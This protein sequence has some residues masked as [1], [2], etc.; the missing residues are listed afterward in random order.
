MKKEIAAVCI[1]VFILAASLVNVRVFSGITASLSSDI[2][3]AR[4]CA[5]SGRWDEAGEKLS[6]CIG[7]WSSLHGYTH[8]FIRHTEI[9]KISDA[10]EEYLG[11]LLSRDI[12]AAE[13]RYLVLI[14][15]LNSVAEMERISLGTVL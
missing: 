11:A 1:L 12:S 14:K 15:Q 13:S 6:A 8:I 3:E 4:T 9:D 7:R 5:R 2:E 10:L